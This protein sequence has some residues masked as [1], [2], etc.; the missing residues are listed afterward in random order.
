M[1]LLL[2]TSKTIFNLKLF[3]I[4][5]QTF[6]ELMFAT[7]I[8]TMLN[9]LFSLPAVKKYCVYYMSEHLKYCTQINEYWLNKNACLNI[10]L[11]SFY[12]KK[13]IDC[14]QKPHIF[15]L[16]IKY[17]RIFK[18]LIEEIKKYSKFSVFLNKINVCF[19]L[20]FLLYPPVF[21]LYT[22]ICCF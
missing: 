19:Y 6:M 4:F 16:I 17:L 1:A 12:T 18:I 20:I 5:S 14:D 3:S 15:L 22:R 7:K 9:Q 13:Y 8:K 2:H 10:V 11:V 21:S